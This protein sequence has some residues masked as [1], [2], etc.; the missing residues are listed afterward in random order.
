[1]KGLRAYLA[2]VFVCS[3]LVGPSTMAEVDRGMVVAGSAPA[4]AVGAEVLRGGGNAVDAAVAVA[5]AMAVTYPEA[6]NLGGGG[7]ML[8]RLADG[9]ATVIDYRETAPGAATRDMYL[10]PESGGVIPRASLDGWRAAGVP[11]TVAGLALALEH[12]GTMSWRDVVEPARRLAAEGIPVT[13]RF[14]A[15]L[16][17]AEAR[18]AADAESRRIY[19]NGGR[20][21]RV[22]DRFVQPDLAETLARLQA[23]GPR[24]FYSGETARRIDAAMRANGGLMRLEDLEAYEAVERE[25][26]RGRY[27]GA[28]IL[29]VPPPSSGGIALLQMLQMLEG[30]DVAALGHNTPAGLHLLAEVMRRAFRDRAVFPADPAFAEVPVRGL[31]DR[32]YCLGRMADFDPQRAT[33]SARMQPGRPMGGESMDTTHFSVL[34]AAGNAVSNTYTLNGLFG[35]AVTV[36]GTG[37]L[38]NNEMDDF[39]ARPGVPNLFGLIQGEANAIAPGKR[40]LSSMTPTIVLRAGRPFLVLGSRGGPT[41]ITQV[42]QVLLNVIDHRM[43]L[44]EAVE[45]PRMHHQWMPDRIDLEPDGFSG[46]IIRALEERGHTVRVW[47]ER[48]GGVQ[49]I[50]VD[51]A[52]GRA[53]GAADSRKSESAVQAP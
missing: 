25:P 6:G 16:A 53:T 51:P 43:P 26:L 41:I 11:G 28:E 1:M 24:E 48:V 3:G 14:L 49:A 37:V 5:L 50:Q 47:P 29:T 20:G 33:P 8:I 21:W 31:I 36:P 52:T 34:D 45:A 30:Y 9:R 17:K 15:Q 35:A 42:L 44:A 12:Y 13:G 10:D 18:L 19:L 46:E 7:F 38:L 4:A 23:A 2:A 40:P 32:G 27:R 39:T 22:G